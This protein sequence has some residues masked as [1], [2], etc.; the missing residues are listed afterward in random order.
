MRLLMVSAVLAMSAFSGIALAVPVSFPGTNTGAIPD[1]DPNGRT[2][3]FAVSGLDG[4]VASVELTTNLTHSWTGDLTATLIAPNGVA[5]LVLLGRAGTGRSIINGDSSNLGGTYLFSDLGRPDL[6]PALQ[7]ILGDVVLPGGSFRPTSRG[8][9]GRS[10]AGGCP[11]SLRGVFT[12]LS[13]AQANGTWTLVVTDSVGSD[14]GGI[15][16]T[17][18]TIDAVSTIFADGFEILPSPAP[19]QFAPRGVSA[20]A[21]C[22]N[23]VQADFTGDGLTDF[24]LA[25]QNGSAIDWLIRENLG[26]GTAAAEVTAFSLGNVSTD[27]IDS[28]D[29]DGDRIADP[30]V[31][32][33][34][35][36]ETGRFQVRL[37][38]RGGALR[39]VQ[40]GQN[41]DNPTQS[42]D[43]DGDGI[44][45]VAV[46]RAPPIASPDG[47]LEIR[48]R[49][50][51]N[52]AL[53]V[54][55]TGTGNDGEQFAISGFDYNG[56]GLADAVIQESDTVT[57]AN[58]RFRMFNGLSGTPF[59]TFVLGLASDFLVPGSH[60]GSAWADV[61]TS[62]T[63]GGNREWRTRDSQTM[64][65]APTVTFGITGD[66]RIGGDYDGDGLS[67]YAFWRP[68]A[69]AGASAFQIRTS[70]DTATVWTLNFGQQNDFP[71]AG[72]R[73]Q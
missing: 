44:D 5:R 24:A 61:T 72:S 57:P 62:R 32:S 66:T 51:S 50:S 12:G 8:A 67:D 10:N 15:G 49:R 11:T 46:Y 54:V 33:P 47:P 17:F 27:F 29:L 26:N 36:G 23:K 70:S 45:D 31:W 25:R 19:E 7:A 59:A 4:P 9:P 40:F 16:T 43:Y 21:H 52:G 2:V 60:V 18:L 55:S 41:G 1:N 37:S 53:G 13:A 28:F 73:V 38:S 68:S 58:G 30:A 34:G 65:E 56:D 63:V 71:V 39:L 22:I 64:V 20:P 69:M 42:G 6:W 3:S 48:Y 35:A 14:T